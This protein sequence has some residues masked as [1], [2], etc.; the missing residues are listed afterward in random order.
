[1]G[2][3]SEVVRVE[4][5]GGFRVTVGSRVVGEGAWRL[6]KAAALVK[7]LALSP[8]HQLHKEQAMDLLWPH[9]GARAAANNLHRTLHAARRVLEPRPPAADS[10]HL[11]LRG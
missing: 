2:G 10:R 1:V 11:R 3:R 7:L 4:L 5:L 9:L 6:R 8:D